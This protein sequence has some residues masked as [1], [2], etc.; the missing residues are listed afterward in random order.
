MRNATKGF[1]VKAS[2]FG[3]YD[4]TLINGKNGNYAFA[5]IPA[6]LMSYSKDIVKFASYQE[7]E[8][9]MRSHFN[10]FPESYIIVS[11]VE[12]KESKIQVAGKIPPV[13]ISVG[14]TNKN[15]R[16]NKNDAYGILG[17]LR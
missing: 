3:L 8:S 4:V 16:N 5:S 7:A 12:W 2:F 10:E 15:E 9:F 13:V 11:L 17:A 1:I 6:S 14:Q